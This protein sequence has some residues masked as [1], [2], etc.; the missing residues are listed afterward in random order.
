MFDPR[1]ASGLFRPPLARDRGRFCFRCPETQII[2]AR[3]SGRHGFFCL[4]CLYKPVCRQSL[5][6]SSMTSPPSPNRSTIPSA[7]SVS[8]P[9]QADTHHPTTGDDRDQE[10]G[11]SRPEPAE[12][13]DYT[14]STPLPVVEAIAI[15]RAKE[16]KEA[17]P[18][19]MVGSMQ[20]WGGF[21]E[22]GSRF[23]PS[24]RMETCLM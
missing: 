6:V 23:S 18:D 15:Q 12:Q 20:S 10:S 21:D 8:R 16:Q 22:G 5:A 14:D 11:A 7:I 13:Y 24:P 9:Q 19:M 3:D 4:T 17:P 2:I 1:L